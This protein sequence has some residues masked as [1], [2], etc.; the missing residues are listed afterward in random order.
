ME[1]FA[2]LT[3]LSG[4]HTTLRLARDAQAATAAGLLC[5]AVGVILRIGAMP[6]LRTPRRCG[7]ADHARCAII[8]PLLL[9]GVYT[10]VRVTDAEL[11]DIR[12]EL[13][14]EARTLSADVDRE[15]TGEIKRLQALAASPSLRQ[16]DFAEFQRQAEAS[17]ALRQSGNIV[18]IDRNMRQLVNIWVPFGTPLE[19]SAVPQAA[20]RALATGKPQITGLFTGHVSNSLLFGII[21]PVEIDG[22]NRYALVRCPLSASSQAWSPHVNCRRAGLRWFP[23][24]PPHRR[25]VRT[26]GCVRRDGVAAGAVASRK[27]PRCVLN[28]VDSKGD[29]RWRPMRGRN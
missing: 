23:T 17:L 1:V 7:I 22:E 12:N 10:G 6:A 4:I 8:A 18:L 29:H 19:T 2:L 9:F 20:E 27:D 14:S 3:Y 16:G 25:A 13:M 28:F 21:V 11:R 26:G 24:P 5:V 15:I